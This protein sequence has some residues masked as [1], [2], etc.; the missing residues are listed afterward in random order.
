MSEAA[1]FFIKFMV[2]KKKKKRIAEF[3]EL[4][5]FHLKVLCS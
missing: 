2:K 5:Y 4:M 3:L 1:N